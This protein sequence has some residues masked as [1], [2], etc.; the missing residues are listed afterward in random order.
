MYFS[1]YSSFCHVFICYVRF[2]LC[3]LLFYTLIIFV[4]NFFVFF[5]FVC[6][7]CTL[8]YSSYKPFVSYVIVNI[9]LRMVILPLSCYPFLSI[10]VG[11]LGLSRMS[12]YSL[13]HKNILLHLILLAIFLPSHLSA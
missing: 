10:I 5:L 6:K 9:L 3:D 11:A 8:K 2:P 7:P 1:N 4:L 13:S 12:F